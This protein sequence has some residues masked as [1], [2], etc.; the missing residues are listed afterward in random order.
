MYNLH[1]KTYFVVLLPSV[2]NNFVFTRYYRKQVD[3][4]SAYFPVDV[5]GVLCIHLSSKA[6]HTV[7]F[8][9]LSTNDL[10]PAYPLCSLCQTHFL[11][12]ILL[13]IVTSIAS[14]KKQRK[15]PSC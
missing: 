8:N 7:A 13:Y 14:E 12:L 10:L 2:L 5:P 9:E 6:W 15:K 11:T 3:N 1:C 4:V